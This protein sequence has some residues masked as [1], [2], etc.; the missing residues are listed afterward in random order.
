MV[1]VRVGA[2]ADMRAPSPSV[3]RVGAER[4]AREAARKRLRVAVRGLVTADGKRVSAIVDK[5]PGARR[6]LDGAIGRSLDLQVDYASDGSVLLEA[7]LPI[8][9]V[10]SAVQGADAVPGGAESGDPAVTGLVVDARKVSVQPAIGLALRAGNEVYR[11]PTV[12]V[13][14]AELAAKDSRA[15]KDAITVRATRHAKGSLT[16]DA[17][18]ATLSRARRSGALVIVITRTSR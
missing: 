13:P 17:P 2:A 8:E 11:G 1:M 7:G 3:A 9:A 6:R 5:D 10:R 4:A 15:G 14:S 18:A 12:F 16:I